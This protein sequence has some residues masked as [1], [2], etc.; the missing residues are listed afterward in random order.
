MD[1]SEDDWREQ[2]ADLLDRLGFMDAYEFVLRWEP[3]AMAAALKFAAW[4]RIADPGAFLRS[5]VCTA[6]VGELRPF[7]ARCMREFLRRFRRHLTPAEGR[8]L[9][10]W[11]EYSAERC[12][13]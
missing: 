9:Q 6:D 7:V 2:L 5:V 10:A 13:H 3:C 11:L 8:T 1:M 12:V 4:Q